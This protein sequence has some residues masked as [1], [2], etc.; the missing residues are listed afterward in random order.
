MEP[1]DVKNKCDQPTPCAWVLLFM[2]FILVLVLI[3]K[4]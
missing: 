1:P 3:L 4:R 2:A